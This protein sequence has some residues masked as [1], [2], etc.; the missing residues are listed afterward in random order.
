M[1]ANATRYEYNG[2]W[3]TS[4]ELA[5]LAGLKPH[6]LRDRLRRGYSVE[7]AV[8]VAATQDS[9]KEF[10]D[11]SYY[12]DWIGMP[13][14]DLYE[15]YW[16]WCIQNGYTALQK[17]GFSRQLMNMYPMLKTIPTKRVDRCYR[18]IRMRD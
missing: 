2:K 9:V 13:I 14:N 8:K 4:I 5:E 6:T 7:E 15:I 1:G 3:Y 10:G 12:L 16:K 11:A 18:I 17:Q